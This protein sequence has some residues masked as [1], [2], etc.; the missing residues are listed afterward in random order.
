M[1]KILLVRIPA[2]TVIFCIL[3]RIFYVF[4]YSHFIVS[5]NSELQMLKVPVFD[6]NTLFAQFWED[7]LIWVE[8]FV[9]VSLIIIVKSLSE[10]FLSFFLIDFSHLL[11]LFFIMCDHVFFFLS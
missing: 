1:T 11:H 7:V 5:K 3:S 8:S 9:V 2:F 10:G 6:R 4:V